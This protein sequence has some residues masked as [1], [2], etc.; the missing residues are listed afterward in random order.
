M[1]LH[2]LYIFRSWL[3]TL[4]VCCTDCHYY[5]SGISGL[6]EY[7]CGILCWAIDMD[8]DYLGCLW[9]FVLSQCSLYHAH[10]NIFGLPHHSLM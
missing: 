4:C 7:L 1:H 6:L 2:V 8:I 3:L 5:Y 9:S 10:Q